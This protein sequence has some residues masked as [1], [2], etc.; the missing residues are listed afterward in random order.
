MFMI[1]KSKSKK[2]TPFSEFI[3][4]ASSREK[5]RVYSDV[6]KKAS[7]R[8]LGIIRKAHAAK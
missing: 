2:S 8:Q 7:E 6:L 3:R 5:K 4:H 1:F